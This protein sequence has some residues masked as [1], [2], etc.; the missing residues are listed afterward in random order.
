H[1]RRAGRRRLDGIQLPRGT[2][3]D[4]VSLH[5]R[6]AAAHLH[7][8]GLRRARFFAR[9]AGL[10]QGRPSYGAVD[11]L[12]VRAAAGGGVGGPKAHRG[13]N[14]RR[15]GMTRRTLVQLAL[16]L[17]AP[18]AACSDDHL[19][20]PNPLAACGGRATQ[21]TLAVGAYT[22]VDP[23]SDS[24]CVTFPANSAADSAEYL[25]VP[26]SVTGSSGATAP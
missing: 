14:G 7:L 6:H 4:R 15:L 17:V 11:R 20:S 12:H 16:V 3:R 8:V 10:L 2:G 26:Q 24:G 21:I 19:A 23:A 18:L 22:S 9:S 5:P 1:A 13:M 25:V